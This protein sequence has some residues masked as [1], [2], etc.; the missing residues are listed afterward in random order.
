MALQYDGCDGGFLF[1]SQVRVSAVLTNGQYRLD[2]QYDGLH[3]LQLT[4]FCCYN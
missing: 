4:L 3:L 2:L 1:F